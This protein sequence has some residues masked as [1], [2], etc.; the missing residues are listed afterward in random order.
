MCI[1][2]ATNCL[3]S[4]PL[5]PVSKLG[6]ENKMALSSC[7][8]KE[9]NLS[10]FNGYHLQL[11]NPNKAIQNYDIGTTFTYLDHRTSTPFKTE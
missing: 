2:N 10:I 9:A 5:I 11:L 6:S 1:K 7:R 8:L 4:F 3:V